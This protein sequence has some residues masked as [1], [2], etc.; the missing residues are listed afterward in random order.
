MRA[1]SELGLM[2]TKTI[3]KRITAAIP[4]NRHLFRYNQ[5]RNYFA[6]VEMMA[7][8]LQ[9]VAEQLPADEVLKLVDYALQRIDRALETIDDSGGFRFAA[10]EALQITHIS[11][12]NRL[13][14]TKNKITSYLLDLA[15]GE[16]QDLY[17]AIPSAYM[18]ALGEDGRKLFYQEIQV[19]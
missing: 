10:I 9:D 17:P 8:Q 12:F 5:V 19:R 4:Y 14:W 16:S 1:D 13:A 7:D 6:P 15:L 11:T 2:D 3:K 18:A